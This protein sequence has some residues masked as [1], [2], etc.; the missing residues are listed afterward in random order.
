MTEDKDIK[1]NYKLLDDIIDFLI[2][3][4]NYSSEII[5]I[6]NHIYHTHLKPI[7][8]EKYDSIEDF[9]NNVDLSNVENNKKLKIRFALIYLISEKLII[10]NNSIVT[11]TYLG[12]V[13]H[14]EGFIKEYDRYSSD[15]TRLINVENFQKR[16][17]R[18]MF[19][20]TLLIMVG[21][22]VA[23]IYYLLEMLSTP[24]C[25]CK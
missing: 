3:K 17:A 14:S 4:D 24:Y 12:I 22:L 1:N 9:F 20:I 5:D 19:W 23:A 21:T 7:E 10:I 13:K 6:I 18:D 16:N 2:L 15:K 25:F 11:I 8:K